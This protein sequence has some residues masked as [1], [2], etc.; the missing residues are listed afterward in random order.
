MS[1]HGHRVQSAGEIYVSQA[2]SRALPG[3]ISQQ[4]YSKGEGVVEAD[5][6]WWQEGEGRRLIREVGD[7][8]FDSG[9]H[10]ISAPIK[11]CF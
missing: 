1:G 6:A 9:D 3:F 7:W 2:L 11:G 5:G 4:V 10:H 8:R